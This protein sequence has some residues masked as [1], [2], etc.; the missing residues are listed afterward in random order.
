VWRG[1]RQIV[2][3][4]RGLEMQ[5]LLMDLSLQEVA[6]YEKTGDGDVRTGVVDYWCYD[7]SGDVVLH[8]SACCFALIRVTPIRAGARSRRR[9][10]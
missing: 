5:V 7:A 1:D 2:V 6:V 4:K 9:I 10:W 8:I 3:T